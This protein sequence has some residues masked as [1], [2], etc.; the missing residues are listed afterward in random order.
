MSFEMTSFIEVFDSAKPDINR[1]LGQLKYTGTLLDNN[2]EAIQL[3]YANM[4]PFDI[5]HDAAEDVYHVKGLCKTF[6]KIAPGEQIPFYKAIFKKDPNKA[7]STS[8]KPSFT[9]ELYF[10]EVL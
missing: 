5:R 7:L 3:M 2:P 9:L 1:R 8:S 6:R 4:I 10:E